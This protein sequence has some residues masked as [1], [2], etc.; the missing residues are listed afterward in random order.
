MSSRAQ[1]DID[2]LSPGTYEVLVDNFVSTSS[3]Q[4]Q[5]KD[6]T[7]EKLG[8]GRS[9]E[10]FIRDSFRFLLEREPK[11]NILK[12]FDMSVISTYFPEY[13]SEIVK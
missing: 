8:N 5:L 10:D 6:E 9:K 2:E 1:I 11:E 13:E 7:Y 12:E 3:H 4:V